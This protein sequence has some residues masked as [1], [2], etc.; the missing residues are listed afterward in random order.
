MGCIETG[1]I[2]RFPLVDGY[3]TIRPAILPRTLCPGIENL[4]RIY[5]FDTH[6][7]NLLGEIDTFNEAVRIKALS[8]VDSEHTAVC[9]RYQLLSWV[10]QRS[11]ESQSSIIEQSICF[12]AIIY[13]KTLLPKPP[14]RGINYTVVLSNM[15]STL[16]RV[17]TCS[18]TA[19]SVWLL[20]I[21]G[22]TS[23]NASRA[24]FIA[25]LLSVTG[26][27]GISTWED[28]K[29]LLLKFWWVE[30]LHEVPCRSLWEEVIMATRLPGLSE[31]GGISIERLKTVNS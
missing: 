10:G 4:C 5:P 7:L 15:K 29:K 16:L 25:R 19:L 1:S 12:G 21:G 23:A 8:A 6:F 27:R 13:I 2:P 26:Q 24:W 11:V 3:L 28:V 17:E 31:V 30:S 14:V 9:I 20:F 18:T 22:S